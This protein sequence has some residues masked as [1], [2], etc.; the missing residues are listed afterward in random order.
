MT[1]YWCQTPLYET[2]QV[3]DNV[4]LV[5]EYANC[6]SCG[7]AQLVKQTEQAKAYTED[8]YGLGENKF[9]EPINYLFN[10]SKKS[11]AKRFVKQIGQDDWVLDV[12][13]GRGDFL[14]NLVALGHKNVA[15]CELG[16]HPK[17][18]HEIEWFAS[19]LQSEGIEIRKYGLV[20]LFHVFEHLP[21]PKEQLSKLTDLVK[22]GGRLVIAIP[23]A[24]SKQFGLY[25]KDWLHFDPPRHLHLIPPKHLIKHLENKGFKLVEEKRFSA[26][27]DPLGYVQSIFNRRFSRRDFFYDMLKTGFWPKGVKEWLWLMFMMLFT[28]ISSP[29]FLIISFLDAKRNQSATIE[30]VFEKR[31]D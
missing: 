22:T 30:M 31:K 27:Y 24:S 29:Y 23:N 10:R 11:L 8:Y 2:Y 20:T 28:T 3:T 26:V 12:G 15:G 9:K 14:L 25:G 5:H 21:N 4:G 1:C 7:T 19:G 18:A 16:N 13:A 17:K 6:P